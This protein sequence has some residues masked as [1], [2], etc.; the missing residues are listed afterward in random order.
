[1]VVGAAG[2]AGAQAATAAPAVASRPVASKRRR[3]KILTSAGPS[4]SSSSLVGVFAG[5]DA[6]D[7]PKAMSTQLFAM[8]NQ[9]FIAR[10]RVAGKQLTASTQPTQNAP[11][12]QPMAINASCAMHF[13]EYDRMRN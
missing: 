2:A 12:A 9:I 7:Q 8:P 1:L 11:T 13:H 6:T 10:C 5:R 4:I 3:E